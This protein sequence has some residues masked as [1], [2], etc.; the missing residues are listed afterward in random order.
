MNYQLSKNDQ[1]PMNQL[2]SRIVIVGTT[3]CGKTTLANTLARRF[4]IAHIELD[5][6]HWDAGWQMAPLEIF[7]ERTNAATAGDAWVA[8]GNY[9]KVRDIV[10]TRAETLI[11]LDYGL[12]LILWRQVWRGLKRSIS[13]EELWNG[14][15]ETLRGQ[16]FSRDSLI[17]WALRTHGR[18]RR[19]Y[20]GFFAQLEYRHLKII[21][22]NSPKQTQAWLNGIP[23]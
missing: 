5:A 14:N 17:L 20:P 8:D 19:T 7:R 11:W 22:F 6:L 1:I 21:R 15:R 9:S 23:S 12:P 3:G 13:H 4:K 2:G 10:W 16:F 18:R